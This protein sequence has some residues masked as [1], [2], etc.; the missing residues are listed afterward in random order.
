MATKK[1][2]VKKA[3]KKA[4]RPAKKAAKKAAPKADKGWAPRAKPLKIK[5]I[6]QVV[7]FAAPASVVYDLLMDSKQ[8]RA[9]TRHPAVVSDQVGGKVSAYNGYIQARNLELVPGNSI[10]QAW[11]ASDWPAGVWSE[12]HWNFETVPGGC[13][14]TFTQTGVPAEEAKALS[15]GWKEYYWDKIK[16]HLKR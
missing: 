2:P 8:H 7:R 16:K 1:K 10:I 5:D 6:T 13:V 14:L 11:R 4:K 9:F 15:R 12:A 3:P